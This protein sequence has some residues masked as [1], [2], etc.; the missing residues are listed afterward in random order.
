MA[1]HQLEASTVRVGMNELGGTLEPSFLVRDTWYSPM[2]VAPWIDEALP[3]D[4]LPMLRGLRGDFFCAPFGESDLTPAETRP[5]GATANRRWSLRSCSANA[6]EFELNARVMGARVTKRVSVRSGH[7][8]VYQE[9]VFTGGAGRIPI[10]HHAMLYASEPLHLG[11]SSLVWAG[12]P[13]TPFE[14]DGVSALL[15]PQQFSDL[16]KVRLATGGWVDLSRYPALEGFEDLLMLSSEAHLEFAWTAATAP[17]SGWVWFALKNPRVLPSTV[18]WLSNG[19][20]GYAPFNHRHTKVIG[21]EEV[22]AYFHLGHRASLE[23]PLL[24]RGVQT[25]I[26]L[27]PSPCVRYVFALAAVP[28]GFGAVRQ[29]V[30]TAGGVRLLDGA[31]REAFATLDL[32]FIGAL[33]AR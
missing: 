26:K 25:C 18:V 27:G 11:C 12:T 28:A 30:A 22:C 19:G 20:R 31:G 17:Q 4:L 9:H 33:P 13:P 32:D 16:S 7:A 29:I 15:Y 10:G 21:L 3:C 2:H 1:D 6:L 8:A 14:P 5:H 23:D 24:E